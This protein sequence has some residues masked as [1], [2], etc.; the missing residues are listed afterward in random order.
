MRE[1]EREIESSRTIYESFLRRARET[2]EQVGVD[3]TNARIISAAFPPEGKSGASRK[4]IIALGGMMGFGLGVVLALGRGMVAGG[5]NMPA[6]APAA[7]VANTAPEA[8]AEPEKPAGPAAKADT[9]TAA[10]AGPASFFRRF[11]RG[12]GKAAAAAETPAPDAAAPAAKPVAAAA[13]GP[14]A[15][16]PV[17]ARL[18]A[19]LPKVGGMSWKRGRA[20][21]V[22]VFQGKG[23]V[24]DSFEDAGSDF[25]KGI[26]QIRAGLLA[27]TE[28][29]A[30]RK[31]LV[32]SLRSGAGCST[33]ALNLALATAI[34]GRTP[35]LVDAGAGAR[36]LTK[37]L[38]GD[39][40]LGFA[41]IISG[42]AGMV[43]AALQDEETGVFFLP[44]VGKE[45]TGSTAVASLDKAV[46]TER[47]FPAARRFDS[48]IVDGSA[49][50]TDQMTQA[51]ADAVDDIVL[52]VR[53]GAAGR[54]DLA[55][56]ESIL[57][58]NAA[59]IRGFVINR[60]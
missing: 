24:V 1:L 51:F 44:R 19:T 54:D 43:R 32:T 45:A 26:R 39:A 12:P 48:I 22:S 50:G 59:K 55:N 14:D 13:P 36:S 58:A 16:A 2:A 60:A 42:G 56:I 38:A 46:L 20:E 10:T 23:F 34:D 7:A 3:T 35:L 17:S 41:D 52:V 11:S 9:A 29:T 4:A 53:A 15:V 30:N 5:S 37:Q 57:G 31:I 49:L 47:F 8:K 40:G 25:A 27:A 21:L 6:P 33:I 28:K 18:L